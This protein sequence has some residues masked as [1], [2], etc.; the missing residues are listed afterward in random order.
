MGGF[1]AISSDD[2]FGSML[3]NRDVQNVIT[4][5]FP[6][7][8]LDIVGYDACLMAM[9]ETAYGLSGH[10]GIMVGSEELE[11]GAGWNYQPWMKALNARPSM[12]P[13]ELGDAV[14]K[15]YADQYKNADLT[16]FSELNLDGLRSTSAQLSA[17]ANAVRSA[18]PGEINN[19]LA[20]RA[21]LLTYGKWYES[22]LRTSVDLL[23]LLQ[24]YEMRTTNSALKAQSAAVRAALSRHILRN[25]ASTRSADPGSRDPY[26]SQGLAIYFPESK[27]AFEE[28]PYRGGY[29]KQNADRPV[30]FVKEQSWAELIY[31]ALGI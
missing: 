27:D 11:P 12:M 1:R 28:D 29:L 9:L 16:T 7:A 18:G 19:L 10:V 23:T 26:G 25:Y 22:S 6:A 5:G 21:S 24:R 20:A 31:A 13:N 30:D 2:D 15:A 14:V 4:Q 17:F 3:Y 8:P